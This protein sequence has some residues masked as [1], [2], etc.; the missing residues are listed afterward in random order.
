MPTLRIEHAIT[1]I[2]PWK[3]AFDRF[4]DVRRD[5]GV[6]RHRIHQPAGDQQY[7]LIDLDFDTATEAERF[8]A[9]LR[10]RVWAS[11]ET[12]PALVGTPAARLLHA[13]DEAP[14]P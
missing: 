8:L 5:A 9:F 10:E 11:P 2:E 13:V 12:A 6:R 7:V 1:G 4:A 3:A 14:L